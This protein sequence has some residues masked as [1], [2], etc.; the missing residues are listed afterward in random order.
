MALSIPKTSRTKTSRIGDARRQD[1]ANAKE[2][3][4][5]KILP[6]SKWLNSPVAI[7]IIQTSDKIR[8]RMKYCFSF[9]NKTNFAC[10]SRYQSRFNTQKRF[11][12]T[13]FIQEFSK[14]AQEKSKDR[15]R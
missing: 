14:S 3:D 8:M 5:Q 9:K 6:R 1:L 15:K 11:Y 7:I 2:K 13:L 10:Q 4:T 12:Q